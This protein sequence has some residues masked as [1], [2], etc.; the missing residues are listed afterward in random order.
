[1]THEEK[2]SMKRMIE[3]MNNKFTGDEYVKASEIIEMLEVGIVEN[4]AV[5]DD[6]QLD[7]ITAQNNNRVND[8]MAKEDNQCPF[9][10]AT[11]CFE[12]ECAGCE[13]S[14][15]WF[16]NKG[17]DE[18]VKD[19]EPDPILEVYE[20]YKDVIKVEGID[21]FDYYYVVRVWWQAIEEYAKA[22]GKV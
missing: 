11:T 12:N 15:E 6:K 2:L 10:M 22:R 18:A 20:K 5:I 14:A 21:V 1:M 3:F 4:D 19:N 13:V 16:A 7:A 9:D 17:K 8:C